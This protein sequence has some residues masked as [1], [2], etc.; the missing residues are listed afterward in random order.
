[1]KRTPF[2]NPA[3]VLGLTVNALGTIRSLDAA[4]IPV[5][6]V[7][8]RPGVWAEPDL[9]M[10]GRTRLCR[11]AFVADDA[12]PSGMIDRLLELG[13]QLP[14]PGVLFP[15]ADQQVFDILDNRDRLAAFYRFVLPDEATVRLCGDKLAF[16]RWAE[17]RGFDIPP[18]HYPK[19]PDEIEA[20]ARQ[21][22][23]PCII[24]PECRDEA[25]DDRFEHRKVLA[26]ANPA[27]LTALFGEAHALTADLVV[28]E[29]IP[30]P[31]SRLIFTH[32]YT[33]RDGTLQA[34]WS[35]RKLRQHPLG[36]GTSTMAESRIDRTAIAI[37]ERLLAELPCPGYSS[38][39]FKKDPR[40]QTYRIMELTLGRTWY[41][42][43]LGTAAG[44]NIPA[45]WYHDVV[46]GHYETGRT[47]VEGIRWIDEYRD[48][49]AGLEQWRGGGITLKDWLGS[50][51][52]R[53]AL[54]LASFR[55]PLPIA[56]VGLRLAM[57]A[58]RRTRPA[59]GRLLRPGRTGQAGAFTT[60]KG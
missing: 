54:A 38:V 59:L 45:L 51:R 31:D 57:A 29:V 26:A 41:P 48:I 17:A 58:A 44:V 1:M 33:G 53:K 47:F 4:G 5:I 36:F 25:W 35:G 55:D 22:R 50:Y 6:A 9:W 37:T 8:R 43:Y 10:S 19:G 40:D 16:Y 11:K 27:E 14:A 13:P 3:V 15:S 56:Y 20:V 28:Q 52:G 12:G 30:G 23:Y 60:K 32:A 24:K 42:H 34:M 2:P 39:E 18:T 7:G 46:G 49:K 21:I